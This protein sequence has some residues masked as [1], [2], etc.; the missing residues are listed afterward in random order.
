MAHLLPRPA[1]QV[2]ETGFRVAGKTPGLP[3]VTDGTL[4]VKFPHRTRGREAIEEIGILPRYPGVRVHDG[5]AAY[6]GY[7]PC[8]HPLCGSH[9]L[10]ER[11]VKHETS[12]LRFM[13][14]PDVRF[15]HHAGE[16]KI[17]MTKVNQGVR[18]VPHHAPRNRMVPRLQLPHLHG[19]TRLPP[20]RRHP[21]RPRRKGRRHPQRALRPTRPQ[22]GVSIY[23]QFQQRRFRFR[24]LCVLNPSPCLQFGQV[25]FTL[26]AQ[27]R[28]D[29]LFGINILRRF[30]LKSQFN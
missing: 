17:R 5:W 19:G 9:L 28:Y 10:R 7:D 6:R 14:D 23:V 2:D 18:M 1:L 26:D 24:V 27:W 16:P 20:S 13:K 4:T 12:V 22:Q 29:F 11:L 3:V 21:H 25:T 30:T 8:R 15:T